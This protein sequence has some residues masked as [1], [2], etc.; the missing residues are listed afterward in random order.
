MIFACLYM[1]ENTIRQEHGAVPWPPWFC[2][3]GSSATAAWQSSSPASV[4]GRWTFAW[5]RR[6]LPKPAGHGV[7][8]RRPDPSEPPT[9]KP[10]RGPTEP[11]WE[12]GEEKAQWVEINRHT[13]YVFQYSHQIKQDCSLMTD[14]LIG[15]WTWP[16]TEASSSTFSFLLR[17]QMTTP[18]PDGAL[19]SV[20]PSVPLIWVIGCVHLVLPA[21]QLFN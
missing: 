6:A 12:P 15:L 20:R 13:G 14:W 21:L 9:S 19:Q 5:R 17:S 16:G 2:W 11:H 8:W 10:C 18:G 3:K 4:Q 1:I 7:Q